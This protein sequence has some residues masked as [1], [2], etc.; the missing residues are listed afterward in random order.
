MSAMVRGVLACVALSALLVA[1]RWLQ[2]RAIPWG[3][4]A[5]V[6]GL[7][8]VVIILSF[9]FL[10][11]FNGIPPRWDLPKNGYASVLRPQTRWSAFLLLGGFLFGGL[12]V[13]VIRTS[14]RA[15]QI[16]AA[17]ALG[18]GCVLCVMIGLD[19][20]ATSFLITSDG[21]VVRRWWSVR[22]VSWKD[23]DVSLDATNGAFVLDDGAH[24]VRIPVNYNGIGA[25]ADV[26]LGR[27]PGLGVT[28]EAHAL[29]R[30][31]AERRSEKTTWKDVWRILSSD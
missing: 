4:A 7:C 28:P 14:K 22:R 26:I 23:V 10:R 17:W 12:I 3:A 21:I 2:G 25:L 31:V 6:G 1:S 5:I 9:S 19:L 29:A 16:H 24:P 30:S 15:D 11:L 20:I 13:A 8:S 27:E 18:A